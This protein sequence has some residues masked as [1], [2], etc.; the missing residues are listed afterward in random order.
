MTNSSSAEHLNP[1]L[2]E[3]EVLVAETLARSF[4]L[5]TQLLSPGSMML[6]DEF[7]R[8]I[9]PT[10][11]TYR[12]ERPESESER[13]TVDFAWSPFW[14]TR[15]RQLAALASDHGVTSKRKQR[16]AYY[17]PRA[18]VEQIVEATM[19]NVAPCSDHT[20]RI[21]DPTCGTGNFLVSAYE[22]QERHRVSPDEIIQGLFG[23]DTDPVAL[24]IAQ[25]RLGLL[26]LAHGGSQLDVLRHHLVVADAL[27][28]LTEY[29]KGADDPSHIFDVI[30]GNPPFL[31]RVR[32]EILR[33][34]QLRNQVDRALEGALHP[35]TDISAVLL[36]LAT[37]VTREGG[38]VGMCQ[39]S[40]IVAGRD[41]AAVRDRIVSTATLE[42]LLIAKGRTFD[43]GTSVV[44]PILRIRAEGQRPGDSS[45]SSYVAKHFGIPTCSIKELAWS[46][47]LS[48]LG[49]VTADFRDQYYW[50]CERLD[51]PL[52][53]KTRTARVLTSGHIGSGF[54]RWDEKSVRI[55]GQQRL[56]PL[57]TFD[58]S[59]EAPP[60][61]RWLSARLQPKLLVATQTRTLECAADLEGDLLPLTPVISITSHEI[62]RLFHLQAV[63]LSPTITSLVCTMTL[64][65]GLSLRALKLSARELR[66]LPLPADHSH[67]NAAAA[68]HEQLHTEQATSATRRKALLTEAAHLMALAYQ[69]PIDGIDWW[70]GA[71][72]L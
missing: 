43:A 10:F 51:Q 71:L 29:A 64:G 25:A 39:P 4:S 41:S 8:A 36:A 57:L 35:Y 5:A 69:H 27:T 40:S 22:Y 37:N 45:W 66:A 62:S 20:T 60:I 17:T 67:W 68:I 7:L 56:R 24:S 61:A 53:G 46:G 14:S 2:Q 58:P 23:I 15:E 6:Y 28:Q 47:Q 50:V 42:E 19:A 32:G 65:T 48:E 9:S 26:H 16:G 55:G 52:A 11:D 63:L 44:A 30:V 49:D 21:L 59:T 38:A 3:E 12:S 13:G 34:V 31:N 72:D 70:T 33:D 18:F 1:L 54:T